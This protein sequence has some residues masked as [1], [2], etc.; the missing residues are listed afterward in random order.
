MER[1]P[2]ADRRTRCPLI[3]AVS[4]VGRQSA[5]ASTR[6]SV[7]RDRDRDPGR[8]R[9]SAA[10]AGPAPSFAIAQRRPERQ[11]SDVAARPRTFA[12]RRPR[13]LA[14]VVFAIPNSP[15][16]VPGLLLSNLS[17]PPAVLPSD[18]ATHQLRR[19]IELRRRVRRC[20]SLSVPRQGFKET[21]LH[22][23][24]RDCPDTGADRRRWPWARL[25]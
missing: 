12:L 3:V 15:T 23:V 5:G 19:C 22:G 17:A 16:V 20:R 7:I 8:D 10:S 11:P 13:T 6:D 14:P 2:A 18:C 9:N 4:H 21:A 1:G 25:E 24:P